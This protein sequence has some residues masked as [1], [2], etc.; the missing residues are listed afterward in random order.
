MSHI[1]KLGGSHLGELDAMLDAVVSNLQESTVIVHGGG[2]LISSTLEAFGHSSEFINGLR[3]TDATTMEVAEMVLAG[4]INKQIVGRLLQR[5]I[6]AVGLSG[7]DGQMATANVLGD[8]SLGLVGRV[9]KVDPKA[10]RALMQAGFVPIVAPLAFHP[11]LGSLNVNGDS[12][13]AALA[14]SLKANSLTLMTNV[15]GLMDAHGTPLSTVTPNTVEQMVASGVVYGGMIPKIEAA[16]LAIRNGVKEV[17][18]R[19]TGVHSGTI[20]KEKSY[21]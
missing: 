5:G 19:S 8:G 15:P 6:R 18:I 17:C 14:G 7:I 9:E 4:R 3:V 12:F 13:A 2:P 1:W 21:V 11:E 20:L 10:L 16:L